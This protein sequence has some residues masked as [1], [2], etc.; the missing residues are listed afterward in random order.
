MNLFHLVKLSCMTPG[1]HT[2]QDPGV[3]YAD[4]R[5]SGSTRPGCHTTHY[6]SI[7]FPALLLVITPITVRQKY[8]IHNYSHTNK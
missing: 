8:F 7:L 3:E 6:Y 4:T 5:V 1:S 2:Y